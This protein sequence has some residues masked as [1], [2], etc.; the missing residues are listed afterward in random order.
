MI[1]PDA[2]TYGKPELILLHEVG[3]TRDSVKELK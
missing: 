2:A 3:Q 1:D